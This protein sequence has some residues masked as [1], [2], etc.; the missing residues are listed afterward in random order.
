MLDMNT[1]PV[2]HPYAIEPSAH[3]AVDELQ[4][5]LHT[6]AH[7]TSAFRVGLAV[8]VALR[9]ISCSQ[10]VPPSALILGSPIVI[11]ATTCDVSQD[12]DVFPGEYEGNKVICKRLRVR[13]P[14]GER[15]TIAEDTWAIH[16]GLLW[17][18]CQGPGVLSFLGYYIHE[19][20]PSGTALYLVS[21]YQE[22]GTLLE[23]LKVYKGNSRRISLIR[24]VVKG[25]DSLHEKGIIHGDIR[26]CNI[27]INE[28]GHAL[29]GG[30]GCACLSSDRPI[31]VSRYPGP[32]GSF[33]GSIPYQPPEHLDALR[34]DKFVF[35][36]ASADIYSLACLMYEMYTGLSP[37]HEISPR[38]LPS[39]R[40]CHIME[41]IATDRSRIPLKPDEQDLA[42]HENG[43]TSEI[44]A[45]MEE[46]WDRDAQR[47]PSA[48][49]IGGHPLFTD[50]SD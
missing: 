2:V 50:I 47:R 22:S 38:R 30:F 29:I 12:S 6:H 21:P 13:T 35:P 18:Y 25:L 5:V 17:F 23:H 49:A 40:A 42:Y 4:R 46:S 28:A 3:L 9:R 8:L 39:I 27:F 41:A 7:Q 16:E 1:F 48:R 11:S 45:L 43:L 24:D 15:N 34:N 20:A 36:S 26:G 31:S 44:W 19:E 37:F 33:I 32:P 14:V 10:R